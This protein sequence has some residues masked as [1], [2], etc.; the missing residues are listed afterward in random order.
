V[1]QENNVKSPATNSRLDWSLLS[2]M[3]THSVSGRNTAVWRFN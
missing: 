2:F 3:T 1:I